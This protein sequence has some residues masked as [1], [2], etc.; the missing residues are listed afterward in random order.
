MHPPAPL[1][2][3]RLAVVD[4]LEV[5]VEVGGLEHG[6][7]VLQVV[8]RLGGNAQLVALDG[9]LH[10]LGALLADHLGDLLCLVLGDAFLNGALDAGFLA[11][12]VGLARVQGLQGDAALDQ[13]RLEHIQ[14]GQ[15]A[16][17]GVCLNED[18][19]AGVVDF[20]AD[21]AEVVALGDFLLGLV[22]GV[23]YFLLVD[24]G[25]D[26]ERRFASHGYSFRERGA[27]AP[28][29]T[30]LPGW[31]L[32][33]TANYQNNEPVLQALLTLKEDNRNM[34]TP[35][36][37]VTDLRTSEEARDLQTLL[38][39]DLHTSLGAEPEGIPEAE[40]LN[41]SDHHEIHLDLHEEDA[42][43]SPFDGI[44]ITLTEPSLVARFRGVRRDLEREIAG[45]M[46]TVEQARRYLEHLEI[47]LLLEQDG[48]TPSRSF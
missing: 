10:A 44:G 35:N 22:Q 19:V 39:I 42:E 43:P 45:D 18:L 37:S 23:G 16:L 41:E 13:L 14:Y 12:G 7:N 46:C 31:W 30:S 47:V 9:C 4:E 15:G 33:F 36:L 29:S 1:D 27:G 48:D 24:L 40:R 26:V 11:G 5:D 20:C 25:D 3:E 6:D 38:F 32:L 28:V 2:P 21:A 17:F 34:T 8:A